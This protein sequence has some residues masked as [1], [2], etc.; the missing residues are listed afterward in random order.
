[1]SGLQNHSFV[2]MNGLGNE[3]LVV[4]LRKNPHLIT[5]TEARAMAG[6]IPFDQLMA[7]YPPRAG[8]GDAF[9]GIFNNDGSEAGACGNGM[10]CVADLLLRESHKPA[11]IVETRAGVLTCWP[12]DAALTA[13]VDMG[14][15]RFNWNDIPLAR[16][17]ADTRVLDLRIATAG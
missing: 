2:K 16:E 5:A 10:R 9:V 6:A 15:P 4:D 8:V 7:I 13:T 14:M 3:I 11:L 12:G 17:W 1:M